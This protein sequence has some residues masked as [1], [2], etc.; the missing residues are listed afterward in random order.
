M[1]IS[2]NSITGWF[3]LLTT[4]SPAVNAAERI[5]SFHSDIYITTDGSMQVEETIQVRAEQDK[6]KR[7]IYRDF[8]TTYRD[9]LGNRYRVD[10][11]VVNV[12]RD[13]VNENYF[14]Q[15][16]TN[17]I[18]TY[19]GR[20]NVILPQ[21]DYTYTFSYTTNRQLGYFESHDEL[22]WNVTGNGWDFPIDSASARIYLPDTIPNTRVT[23]EAYTGNFGSQEQAFE[24]NRY[25]GG[26]VFIEAT[27]PLNPREGLTIVVGWPKGYVT[28]PSFNQK[29]DYFYNDNKHLIVGVSGLFLVLLYYLLVWQWVGMDPEKGVIIA[30]YEPPDKY[31]PASIRFIEKMGYDKQSFAVALINL[32]VKDYLNI[33]EN[34]GQYTLT[35][36]GKKVR[37]AAGESILVKALF[38]G[39]KSRILK[40]SNHRYIKE[41]LDAHENSL[42][43]DYEKKYFITNSRYFYL[44]LLITI[45]VLIGSTFMT[46][47][48]EKSAGTIFMVAWLTG[49]SSGVFVLIKNA[50]NAWRR[51]QGVITIIVAVYATIFAL[52][53]T[54]IELFAIAKVSGILNWGFVV[55]ILVGACINWLFYELLKAPTLAGR[56]LLNRIEGFRQYIEVAEKQ[57]LES[58]HPQG[59]CPELFES[60][61]PYALALGIEQTWAEKFADVLVKISAKGKNIYHPNWYSGSGWDDNHIG[62]FTSSLGNSFTHAISSS[63]TAPGSSSGGGVAADLLEEAVAEEEAVAGS[64]I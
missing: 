13:G 58:R 2:R 1:Q 23:A 9:L 22:Y 28:E 7:G 30:R 59:R 53:F 16:Q 8:P 55:L 32:A 26:T 41:A 17:G 39:S 62:D 14:T 3:L 21:G 42:E 19:F 35:K 10:F 43:R 54:G 34:A 27:R 64:S 51:V 31:S 48:F 45:T 6:I 61:L 44:G 49:W 60:Y 47:D 24:E 37:M 20:E 56:K 52:I 57:E 25:S 18:R 38:G 46:S 50:I 36:T 33:S 29:L 11:Q 15:N 63:S 40:Q 5:L 12:Q 4:I